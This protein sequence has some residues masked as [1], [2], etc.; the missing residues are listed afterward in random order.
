M[1]GYKSQLYG[2]PK[3]ARNRFDRTEEKGLN[4]GKKAEVGR[5]LLG[6][7]PH[8]HNGDNINFAYRM[9]LS[10]TEYVS[11]STKPSCAAPPTTA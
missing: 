7:T 8:D 6:A 3:V 4:K 2:S 11:G 9:D 1:V 5:Y 10:A